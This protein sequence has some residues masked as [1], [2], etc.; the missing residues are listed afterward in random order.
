MLDFG[1]VFS[2]KS[3]IR[4]SGSRVRGAGFWAY[5]SGKSRIRGSGSRVRGAGLKIRGSGGAV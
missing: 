5:F 2:G 3:R 4:D 1:L